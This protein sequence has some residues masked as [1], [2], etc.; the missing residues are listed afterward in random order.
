MLKEIGL[1]KKYLALL[2]ATVTAPTAVANEISN[3]DNLLKKTDI[4]EIDVIE[5]N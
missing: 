3:V 2:I 1:Q 5:V 4:N